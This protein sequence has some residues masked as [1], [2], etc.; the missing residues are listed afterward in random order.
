MTAV[1]ITI[2]DVAKKAGVSV[3]TAS[4][5]CNNKGKM[6]EQTRQ[7]ILQVA[8][9]MH[10]S[11]NALVRSLQSGRTHTVGIFTWSMQVDTV[12][13]I[14]M[15]LLKGISDSIADAGR[16]MLIYSH[17]AP[18][19]PLVNA[20][21]FLDGRVDGLI[22]G[23]ANL[24]FFDL[25]ALTNAGLS[26]VVLYCRDVPAGLGSVSIDNAA[27]IKAVMDHLVGL[28]H[29]RI[30]FCAPRFTPDYQERFEAVCRSRSRHGLEH[31]PQLD[32]F[33]SDTS[34][35]EAAAACAA[36]VALPSPPT[37]IV[38]GDD[39]L[40]FHFIECLTGH[41]LRVPVD[42]SVVGFDDCPAAGSELGLTTVRQPAEE[43]GRTAGLLVDR[44][45][46]GADAKECRVRLPVEL[47]IRRTTA[48]ASPC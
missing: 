45:I 2:R 23:P 36:L 7:R 6:T 46:G 9:E 38:A 17:S 5:A 8:A 1:R 35:S 37:A 25:E 39:S 13:N 24:S 44:L 10:F 34:A 11:P 27:G 3:G 28:G 30:A 4:K 16:D 22:L 32:V 43:V 29:R 15:S 41:G 21:K 20:A 12:H 48:P 19:K 40:A 18:G 33:I 14:A 31:D 47:V 26:T 42:I